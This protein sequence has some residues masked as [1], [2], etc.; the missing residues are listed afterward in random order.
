[1]ADR[2][3]RLTVKAPRGGFVHELTVHTIGAVIAPG[4]TLLH[5]VPKTDALVIEAKV[6]PVDIDQLHQGQEAQ[7]R[8][9]AFNSRTTPTLNATIR[10]ISADQSLNEQTGETYY[11]ARLI[12]NEGEAPRLDQ[13]DAIL[14]GMPAEVLITSEERTVLS[15]LMKPLSDQVA[16][17]FREE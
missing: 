3:A 12:L 13:D 15:Y 2:R 6:R 5:I 7:I 10:S 9:P 4:E 17:A 16:R 14:A 1:M 8:F 11:T